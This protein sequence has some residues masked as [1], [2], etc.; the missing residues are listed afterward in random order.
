LLYINCTLLG[1]PFDGLYIKL[2]INTLI[3]Y[4]DSNNFLNNCLQFS[5]ILI[6]F[7]MKELI[8]ANNAV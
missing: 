1:G 5:N 8:G 7:K 4:A 2:D 3:L 6:Y